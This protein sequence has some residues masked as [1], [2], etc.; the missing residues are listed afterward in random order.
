MS[1]RMAGTYVASCNCQLI[2]PCPTD[3]PPTGPGGECRG[4]AVFGIANGNLD[5]VDLS[6]TTFALCNLFPSNLTAGNWKLGVVI[7][8]NASDAQA[9]A[10]ER[11]VHGDEGGMF[12]E[13]SGLF[14]EWLGVERAG[15]S[16]SNGDSPTGSIGDV[17]FT[18]E[19]SVGPD[20]SPTTV[21]GAPFAFAPEYRV[22]KAPTRSSVF[23]LDFDGVYGE[24]ASYEWSS[25]PVTGAPKG[26]G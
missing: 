3:N 9:A 8:E 23:G 7:D 13:L 4:L 10:I 20:G 25:E 18:F 14:G 24:A 6:G 17:S 12:A 22:G 21:R 1:W 26:R 19:P 16:V 15:V 5:D 2:C 11:V